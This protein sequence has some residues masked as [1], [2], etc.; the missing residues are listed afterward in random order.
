MGCVAWGWGRSWFGT[1]NDPMPA[2]VR[3]HRAEFQ[4]KAERTFRPERLAALSDLSEPMRTVKASGDRVAHDFTSTTGL[5][6]DYMIIG[7]E[8]NGMYLCGNGPMAGYLPGGDVEE[9][10]AAVAD[11]LGQWVT[12]TLANMG[13]IEEA[14]TWP[15]CSEHDHAL[16]PVVLGGTAVW[17]C[18]DDQAIAVRIGDL[19]AAPPYN[20]TR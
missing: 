7:P 14:R 4:A 17:T 9:F 5:D 13:R 12:E 19:K 8:D 16:D 11:S 1:S 20:V 15:R 3:E 10:V 18:R 2:W 6:M